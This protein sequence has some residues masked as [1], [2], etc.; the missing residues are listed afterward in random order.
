MYI[1]RGKRNVQAGTSTRYLLGER[2][3]GTPPPVI[4]EIGKIW[5]EILAI[6]K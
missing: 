2:D 5:E 1:D 3:G 6:K 4:R